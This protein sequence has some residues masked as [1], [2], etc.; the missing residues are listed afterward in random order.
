MRI[1]DLIEQLNK[2]DKDTEIYIPR[3]WDLEEPIIQVMGFKDDEYA[4]LV[5]R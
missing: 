5:T 4:L 3:E 2:L 1:A